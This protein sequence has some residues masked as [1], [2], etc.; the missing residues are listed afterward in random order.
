M[1]YSTL[2]T[3]N[4]ITY[5]IDYSAIIYKE[6]VGASY[7]MY[8]CLKIEMISAICFIKYF[9]LLCIPFLQQSNTYALINLFIIEMSFAHEDSINCN[10]N[11]F[12]CRFEI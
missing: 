12:E 2:F 4:L 5:F 1:N 10:M 3:I 11:R 6:M 7:V 8:Y 9:Q